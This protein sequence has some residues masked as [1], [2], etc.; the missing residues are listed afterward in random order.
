MDSSAS[1]SDVCANAE[2]LFGRIRHVVAFQA[3]PSTLKSAFLDPIRQDLTTAVNIDMF[4]RTDED[5]MSMFSGEPN[6]PATP[7]LHIIACPVTSRTL[8]MTGNGQ[9][10][11]PIPIRAQITVLSIAFILHSLHF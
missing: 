5:F 4:A 10:A 3:T 7:R 8:D 1:Y 9:P 6:D 11:P 2:R